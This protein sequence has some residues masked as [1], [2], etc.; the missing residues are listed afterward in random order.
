LWRR[1]YKVAGEEYHLLSEAYLLM[2]VRHLKA[3]TFKSTSPLHKYTILHHNFLGAVLIHL[4]N[5]C[6]TMPSSC[7]T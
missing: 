1:K 6:R 7:M 5:V 4:C 2:K 3:C